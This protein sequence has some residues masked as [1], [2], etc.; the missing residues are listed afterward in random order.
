M[1]KAQKIPVVILLVALTPGLARAHEPIFGIGPRTIWKNGFGLETEFE[2]EREE[3]ENV[4]SLREEILYGITADVA[5]TLEIPYLLEKSDGRS[6]ASGFGDTML[7]GKWRFYRK[8]VWGGI[9]HAAILGGVE[10]PTGK[11]SGV[12]LGSGS[13]DYFTGL[14]GAYE[15]RRWL[16]FGAV[17]YRFNTADKTGFARPDVFL[18]D[19]AVGFRPVLTEYT[20]P[21]VVL[22][23]EVNGEVFRKAHRNGDPVAGTG[24][25]RMFGAFGVWFTY[26][27]W[28]FKPGVQFPLVQNMGPLRQQRDFRA[29]FAVE[30]H[31]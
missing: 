5:L 19:A 22:M 12:A 7:R 25:D 18:Y 6:Q 29:V 10:F 11:T 4:W 8:E 17:R 21:D 26:R 16:N 31:L 20:Q 23:F 30:F 9:Y 27:N 13:Y 14:A 3:V 15:G 1:P 2:R 28:A 24:G